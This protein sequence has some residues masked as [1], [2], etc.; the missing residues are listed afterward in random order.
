LRRQLRE[1]AEARERAEALAA[2]QAQYIPAIQRRVEQAWLRPAGVPDGLTCVL[3]VRLGID[4]SVLSA[5]VI[6]SSGNAAFDRSAE[7]A[8]IKASPLPIPQDPQI[9]ANFRNLVFRF[10]PDG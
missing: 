3:Q 7:Q 5:Q 9:A 2:A 4:G 1:E 6:Q 8:V 10:Q